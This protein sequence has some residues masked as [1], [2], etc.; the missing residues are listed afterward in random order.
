[1]IKKLLISTGVCGFFSALCINTYASPAV[2]LKAAAS[3]PTG[4]ASIA[5]QIT[6]ANKEAQGDLATIA[7]SGPV[8][9]Q[10][11]CP[12]GGKTTQC[13][14]NNLPAGQYYISA[15]GVTDGNDH[16]QG[17]ATTSPV[18]LQAGQQITGVIDYQLEKS[19]KTAKTA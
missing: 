13:T 3:Q 5:F 7:I 10:V 15:M 6:S 2:T 1:M 17:N 11:T 16:Y 14:I 8:N 12:I 9:N 19:T 4:T 18:V